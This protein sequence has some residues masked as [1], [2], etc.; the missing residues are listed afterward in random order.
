MSKNIDYFEKNQDICKHYG[1][2]NQ[3]RYLEKFEKKE[4][5]IAILNYEMY[6]DELEILGQTKFYEDE[7]INNLIDEIADNVV[8]L[9]Q[10]SGLYFDTLIYKV[11][12]DNDI[13]FMSEHYEQI[14]ARIFYKIDRQLERIANERR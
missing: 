1:I 3:I 9:S 5:K 12:R 2:H 10:T 14:I 7:L 8:L 13:D 6:K 11:I 4:L